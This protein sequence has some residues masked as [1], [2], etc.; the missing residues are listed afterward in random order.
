M[1]FKGSMSTISLEVWKIIE[2]N[3][4]KCNYKV[5]CGTVYIRKL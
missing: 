5:N 1:T 2:K 3:H 4:L